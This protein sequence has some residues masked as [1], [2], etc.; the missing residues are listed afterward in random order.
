VRRVAAGALV[1]AAVI[2]ALGVA[3]WVLF[4]EAEA[5]ICAESQ[6]S[7]CWEAHNGRLHLRDQEGLWPEASDAVWAVRAVTADEAC[8]K[9]GIHHQVWGANSVSDCG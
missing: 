6:T 5:P 4:P 2:V 3:F 9:L 8:R 7:I 1:T